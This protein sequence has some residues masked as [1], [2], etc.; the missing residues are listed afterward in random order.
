MAGWQLAGPS[1]LCVAR[2]TRG[3]GVGLKRLRPSST[4]GYALE[5]QDE[6]STEGVAAERGED[7][8]A[9]RVSRS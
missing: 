5:Q 4:E 9:G 1:W 7:G 2:A 6:A 3:V 8:G